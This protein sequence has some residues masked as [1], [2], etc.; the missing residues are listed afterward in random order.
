[1]FGFG[2]ALPEAQALEVAAALNQH[3]RQSPMEGDEQQ[4]SPDALRNTR[5]TDF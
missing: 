4:L 3:L 2:G 5:P 1:M